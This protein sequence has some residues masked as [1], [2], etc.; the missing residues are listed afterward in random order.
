MH[1][2]VHVPLK[3]RRKGS[4]KTTRC[5]FLGN[6]NNMKSSHFAD[7]DK[8]LNFSHSA[9]VYEN[10]NWPRLHGYESQRQV[11]LP[12]AESADGK[13]EVTKQKMVKQEAVSPRTQASKEIKRPEPEVWVSSRSTKGIPP[14]QFGTE[15]YFI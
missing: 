7:H 12:I 2:W 6:Q 4:A 5:T 3:H 15:S 14:V 10:S 8:R 9:S 13:S 11:M 1:A